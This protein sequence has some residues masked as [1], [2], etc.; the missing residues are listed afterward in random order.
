MSLLVLLQ[1]FFLL[2]E[3]FTFEFGLFK[4]AAIVVL[5]SLISIFD[6][7]KIGRRSPESGRGV[8][9]LKGLGGVD[10]IRGNIG[11]R[12]RIV[13]TTTHIFAF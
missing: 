10:R 7:G 4:Q 12:L 9:S 5:E 8:G 2:P 6:D 1:L 11:R 13:T 3:N